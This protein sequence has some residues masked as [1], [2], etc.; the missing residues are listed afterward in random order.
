M[1]VLKSGIDAQLPLLPAED[2]AALQTLT[3]EHYAVWNPANF[4]SATWSIPS[5]AQAGCCAA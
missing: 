4:S 2:S 1:N 3:D 5:S